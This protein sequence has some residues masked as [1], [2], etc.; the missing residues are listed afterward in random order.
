[1]SLS[2]SCEAAGTCAQGL[3]VLNQSNGQDLGG[4]PEGLIR[5]FYES[6]RDDPQMQ[7]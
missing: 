1:M 7:G 2:G 3:R 4:E 6:Y 5:D